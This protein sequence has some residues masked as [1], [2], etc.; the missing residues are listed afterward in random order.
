MKPSPATRINDTVSAITD[1]LGNSGYAFANVNAV[2][3]VDKDK[4]QVAFTFFV[5]PGR[6]YCT[7]AASMWPATPAPA[8]K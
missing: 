1:L 8:T 5:D 4:H 2:P 3:E 7:C 6:R